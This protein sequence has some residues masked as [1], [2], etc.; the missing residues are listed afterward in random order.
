MKFTR[1]RWCC[2]F[3]RQT[4]TY[5][6]GKSTL[7][8]PLPDWVI[9]PS[10][11]L[12]T[13]QS[14]SKFSDLL[15][16]LNFKK[17]IIFLFIFIICRWNQSFFIWRLF[18]PLHFNRRILCFIVHVLCLSLVHLLWLSLVHIIFVNTFSFRASSFIYETEGR[19][20]FDDTE[21]QFICVFCERI[22]SFF[23]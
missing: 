4:Y 7:H 10:H 13:S 17:K 5:P 18:L 16:N 23:A 2:F 20:I 3:C 19:F 9:S 1:R 22:H 11:V 15:L 8:T 12:L 6:V 14:D 21:V